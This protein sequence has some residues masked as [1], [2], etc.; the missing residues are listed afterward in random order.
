MSKYIESTLTIWHIPLISLCLLISSVSAQQP[1]EN[2]EIQNIITRL[3]S[4]DPVTRAYAAIDAYRMGEKA[5]PAIP[6]LIHSLDD[7]TILYWIPT[8]MTVIDPAEINQTSPSREAIKTLIKIGEPAILPV[9]ESLMGRD[10]WDA[11]IKKDMVFPAETEILVRIGEPAVLPL[12]DALENT[13]VTL[14]QRKLLLVT[15]GHIPDPRVVNLMLPLL[16]DTDSI[17]RTIGANSLDRLKWKPEN[18]SQQARFCIAKTD[19]NG[20]EDCGLYAVDP[21]ID[22]LAD[23]NPDIRCGAVTILGQLGDTSAVNP[24]IKALRDDDSDVRYRAAG[25]LASIKDLRAIEPLF[26]SMNDESNWVRRYV[27]NALGSFGQNALDYLI[28]AGKGPDKN[29][30][31]SA[32]KALGMIDD[33]QVFT[34]LKDALFDAEPEVRENAAKELTN[35]LD[36]PRCLDLLVPILFDGNT[37]G[38]L[39]IVEALGEHRD[40]RAV[41]PLLSVLKKHASKDVR[42]MAIHS[43]GLIGDPRAVKP[44]SKGLKKWDADLSQEATQT[45][46]KINND[47]AVI[48]LVLALGN[49]YPDHTRVNAAYALAS[50]KDPKAVFVLLE[51][52]KRDEVKIFEKKIQA[53]SKIGRP[54]AEPLISQLKVEKRAGC[55]E[56]IVK[57]LG[58]IEA[59]NVIQPLIETL[60]DDYF[61]VR[62]EAAV[63]LGNLGDPRAVEALIPLL[64]DEGDFS[65]REE[66]AVAL[67]K[68]K[69]SRSIRPL[70]QAFKDDD[71]RVRYAAVNALSRM[72]KQAMEPL[73]AA[74]TDINLMIRANAIKAL[75]MLEDPRSIDFLIT[76]LNDTTD[77][78]R[79]NVLDALKQY[80]HEPQVCHTFEQIALNDMNKD[81]RRYAVREVKN[82]AVLLEI[83]KNDSIEIIRK[84]AQFGMQSQHDLLK[85]IYTEP[86]II[87]R[88]EALERIDNDTLLTDIVLN[89]KDSEIHL[90]AVRKI[91]DQ[92][93][94]MKILNRT[95]DYNIQNSLVEKITDQS[96]LD[97]IAKRGWKDNTRWH[98]R[99]RA[100]AKIKN[101]TLLE[102]LALNDPDESIREDAEKRL[103][104]IK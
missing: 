92:F 37:G 88:E 23:V 66:A 86:S 45:L 8:D 63:A 33:P 95:T 57:A 38:D 9:I 12:L 24:L 36:D 26:H 40:P 54:A 41:E 47:D 35:H 83:A 94:L 98:L 17:F 85:V 29:V 62:R 96:V 52:L 13:P 65:V 1:E 22:V 28:T 79:L 15:L 4:H 48:S 103:K 104:E 67:G 60:Q 6:H 49:T 84:M 78:I 39:Q 7:H 20:V 31:L 70:I 2:R 30:R 46:R 18:F 89:I 101:R 19:W 99:R 32:V 69:D 5:F 76:A 14:K 27:A 74:F 43:L 77:R 93:L 21:L 53:L 87:Y 75:G 91:H 97:L 90:P 81:V 102:D 3:R 10:F 73:M 82:K 61:G 71:Y 11:T 42:K 64:Q 68:L 56:C 80:K 58:E 44:L 59:P 72:G 25:A 55:R 16:G 50:L 34:M 51:T 100:I